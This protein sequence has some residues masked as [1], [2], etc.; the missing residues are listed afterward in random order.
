METGK[1]KRVEGSIAYVELEMSSSCKKC[2][3]SAICS[4]GSDG[5]RELAANNKAGAS[6]GDSV[7]VAESEWALMQVSL[8]QYGIP[9]VGFVGGAVAAHI[10]GFT[11]AGFIPELFLFLS[12]F[13]GLLIGG[14][15]SR[16]WAGHLAL[17]L[18]YVFEVT[19]IR[20]K[21]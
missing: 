13:T 3:A 10:S 20:K 7:N 11:P 15:V 9:L 4:T 18:G 2:G 12:G 19:D 21:A 8:M 5:K 16:I 1:I 17:S 6:A 14:V